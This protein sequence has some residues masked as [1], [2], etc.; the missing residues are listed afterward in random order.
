[1]TPVPDELPKLVLVGKRRYH[2]EA[3]E[4]AF[5]QAA[6]DH[7]DARTATKGTPRQLLRAL[8]A[9]KSKR[10]HKVVLRDA[11]E[12]VLKLQPVTVPGAIAAAFPDP[13]QL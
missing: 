4:A 6:L 8:A 5:N 10:T 11:L 3:F 1:M 13:A 9:L 7:L 2:L 12:R